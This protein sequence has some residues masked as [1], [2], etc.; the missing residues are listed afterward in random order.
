MEK[1]TLR[2]SFMVSVVFCLLS[3][4]TFA[5]GEKI[6]LS[7]TG[8][9]KPFQQGLKAKEEAVQPEA[10]RKHAAIEEQ[11]SAAMD[12]TQPGWQEA[13]AETEQKTGVETE[14]QP[15]AA[16]Q[17]AKDGMVLVPAGEFTMGC[18]DGGDS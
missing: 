10:V 11:R 8:D 12:E 14:R 16:E 3:L 6:P 18:Q 7:A 17:S 15:Q 2:F 4:W 5:Q 9:E 1:K 13:Q